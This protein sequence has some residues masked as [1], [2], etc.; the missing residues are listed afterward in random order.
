MLC[1][2]R[3]FL[4]CRYLYGYLLQRQQAL[5]GERSFRSSVSGSRTRSLA[6]RTCDG[7]RLAGLP[8]LRKRRL[9]R[10]R[11]SLVLCPPECA[12]DHLRAV[13]LHRSALYDPQ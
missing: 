13:D 1:Y 5:L 9:D 8:Q 10:K 2:Q 11:Y 3:A 4:A 7:Y 6:H 12:S